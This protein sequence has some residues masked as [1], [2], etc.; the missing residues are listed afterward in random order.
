MGEGDILLLHTDGITEHRRGN[1]DYYFPARLEQT[2]REV[3]QRTAE[4]IFDAV[5]ADM[6][7]FA[8]PSDDVS[9]VVIKRH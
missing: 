1:D 6:L 5:M 4:E 9:L 8:Q 7:A 2:I 3:K